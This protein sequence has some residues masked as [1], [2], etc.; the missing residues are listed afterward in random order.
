MMIDIINN[1]TPADM[2]CAHWGKPRDLSSP[3][4]TWYP[5]LS[6][7]VHGRVGVLISMLC[8]M[9]A[10]QYSINNHRLLYGHVDFFLALG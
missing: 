2:P 8:A 4:P 6:V 3:T 10:C 7:L 9:P 5:L 1:N